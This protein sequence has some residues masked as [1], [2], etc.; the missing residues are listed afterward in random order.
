M[1]E[2]ALMESMVEEVE[3]RVEGR[4]AVVRLELGTLAGVARDALRFAFDVC[5]EKTV[6]EGATLEIVSIP[7]RALCRGCGTES[8]L[9]AYA[10]PCAC[11]CFDRDLVCGDEIRVREVEVL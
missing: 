10:T 2:L 1:H 3:Q 8:P 9:E 7:A 4:V 6:L 5:T 11:G